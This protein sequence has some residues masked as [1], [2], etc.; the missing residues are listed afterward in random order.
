L[1]GFH[2]AIVTA[3][4]FEGYPATWF[5]LDRN[6]RTLSE[7]VPAGTFAQSDTV[8][9]SMTPRFFNAPR[10]AHGATPQTQFLQQGKPSAYLKVQ[11]DQDRA[12]TSTRPLTFAA[13]YPI[14]DNPNDDI[15]STFFSDP[16]Q[17]API[18]NV[19][20]P[21]GVGQFR[22]PVT[23]IVGGTRSQ[24]SL[25]NIITQVIGFASGPSVTALFPI[26]AADLTLAANVEALLASA[27]T[28]FAPETK[29]QYWINNSIIQIAANEASA[30]NADSDVLQLASE[31]TLFAVFPT[32]ES[33]QVESAVKAICSQPG[34]TFDMD[35]GGALIALRNGSP[36]NP[37]PFADFVYITYR[38][39]VQEAI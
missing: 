25:L 32:G 10:Q 26:A 34:V 24:N 3:E 9:V 13:L 18:S 23:A 8:T 6:T 15:S 4:G 17:D 16:G 38:A 31:T 37:N 29:Q 7:N 12:G 28:A 22:T 35:R 19:P 11:L 21:G 36:V 2:V 27:A 39:T 33:D 1:K 5:D 30:R 14:V 20:L